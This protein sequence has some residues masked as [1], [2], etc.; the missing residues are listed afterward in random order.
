MS[1]HRANGAGQDVGPDLATIQNRTPESLLAEILAPNREILANYTQYVV[2]LEDGRLASGMIA[3]ESPTSI[4]LK[5]AEGVQETILRQNI[6]EIRGSGKS[7]MPEGLEQSISL[8]EM[9][10]L[11]TFL[12]NL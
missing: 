4:S 5:R 9:S 2:M 6:E 1:C 3:T 7:L 12:K 10:D 8:E 11:I